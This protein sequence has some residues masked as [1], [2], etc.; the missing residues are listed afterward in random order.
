MSGGFLDDGVPGWPLLTFLPLV[1]TEEVTG[2]IPVSPTDVRVNGLVVNGIVGQATWCRL[3]V[4]Q[5][6]HAA[7]SR[8][9]IQALLN[10]YGRTHIGFRLTED[11]IFGRLTRVAVIASSGLSA[12]PTM[13]SSA[14]SPGRCWCTRRYA[15]RPRIDWRKCSGVRVPPP[16]NL[17]PSR[18]WLL[19]LAA[20]T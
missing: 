6:F 9:A 4:A 17:R 1:H 16:E 19:D 15:P 10:I 13:A 18:Y 14:L 5:R 11:G 20:P 2:S 3:V 7:A 12:S 8:F